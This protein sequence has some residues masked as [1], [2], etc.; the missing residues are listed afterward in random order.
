MA[1]LLVAASPVE[2]QAEADE[3]A[4]SP[5]ARGA[6]LHLF[7]ALTARLGLADGGSAEDW[8]AHRFFFGPADGPVGAVLDALRAR[9]D[10][11]E[12]SALPPR[13]GAPD[14]LFTAAS[15]GE[16]AAVL[17]ACTDAVTLDTVGRD[18]DAPAP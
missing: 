14:T 11:A 13:G 8:P 1:D 7:H 6:A 18:L 3:A 16:H 5:E 12:V 2:I 15:E 9:S 17:V 10:A 4:L